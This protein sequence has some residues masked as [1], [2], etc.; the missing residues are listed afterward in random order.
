MS[1]EQPGKQMQSYPSDAT[2]LPKLWELATKAVQTQARMTMV[3]TTCSGAA[4][5]VCCGAW[6]S[7]AE[8]DL[9][10]HSA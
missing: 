10:P 8:G 1:L 5:D 6:P 2:R 4:M 9:R 3:S 7:S